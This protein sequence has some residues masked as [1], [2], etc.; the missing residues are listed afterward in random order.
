[1]PSPGQKVLAIEQP[2]HTKEYMGFSGEISEGYGAGQVTSQVMEKVE[3]LDAKPDK[4][5]FNR[6]Q[7]AGVERF[8]L[9]RTGGKN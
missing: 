2:T 6:Y 1:M 3:V 4:I 9:I 5:T 8:A 7:G